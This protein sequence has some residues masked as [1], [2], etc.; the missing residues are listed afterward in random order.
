M[1]NNHEDKVYHDAIIL[2]TVALISYIIVHHVKLISRVLTNHCLLAN[3]YEKSLLL[4]FVALTYISAAWSS[5]KP[6]E[7]TCDYYKTEHKSYDNAFRQGAHYMATRGR[8]LVIH[9]YWLT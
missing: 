7:I 5:Q 8:I 1:S 3:T 9:D 6:L 4:V 2:Q